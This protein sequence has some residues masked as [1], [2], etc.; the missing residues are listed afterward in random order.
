MEKQFEI[1]KERDFSGVFSDGINFL[2]AHFKPILKSFVFIVIP[3]YTIA[4]VL[5]SLLSSQFIDL[6]N[7]NNSGLTNYDSQTV[8]ASKANLLGF[9]V[10]YLLYIAAFFLA[11][12]TI[13]SYIKIYSE[14]TTDEKIL[15]N[16]VWKKAG[17]LALKLFG[18]YFVHSIV[19]IIP[20]WLLFFLLGL[21]LS[22]LSSI[23]VIGVIIMVL[24]I[25]FLLL[26]ATT[27]TSVLVSV[28]LYEK[29]GIFG[30]LSRT[31][32]LLRGSFWQTTGITIIA[33]MLVQFVFMGLYMIFTMFMGGFGLYSESPDMG[34]IKILILIFAIIAPLVLFLGYIFQF[35]INS[36][37][38]FSLLEKLD[39]VGLK[40]KVESI[41]E[42]NTDKPAEEY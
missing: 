2:K 26:L 1:H 30:S 23:S 36:F 24:G 28:I 15:P 39:H 34:L 40:M 18:Y 9:T 13:Y 17:R 11:I 14:R 32:T 25:V 8:P 29:A 37:T 3:V 33:A 41:N 6:I 35:S 16:E 19:F 27:Y 7:A 38:Y 42:E 10:I 22:V 20:I 21:L 5:V 12:T 31:A 4:T